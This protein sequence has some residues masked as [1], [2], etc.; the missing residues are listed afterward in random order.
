MQPS[1]E[2]LSAVDAD[3]LK[4]I[5]GSKTN[6]DLFRVLRLICAEYGY[7]H[8]MVAELPKDDDFSFQEQLIVSNWDPEIIRDF[9]LEHQDLFS[10]LF[11]ALRRSIIPLHLDLPVEVVNGQ[12]LDERNNGH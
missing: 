7:R 1:L 11:V 5:D 9:E 3:F 12:D 4:E 2:I 6:Y 10:A 8:F